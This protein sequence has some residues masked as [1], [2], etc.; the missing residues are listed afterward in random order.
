M[1][2]RRTRIVS[3]CLAAA[4]AAW[5][6][7]AGA[8]T[9]LAQRPPASTFEISKI[10]GA[11]DD[12]TPEE[13]KLLNQYFDFYLAIFYKPVRPDDQA[14]FRTKIYKVVAR[15][16]PKTKAH[17]FVN[18]KLLD[19]M[20]GVLRSN[21]DRATKYNAML[22]IGD[23]NESEELRS[24]RPMPDALRYLASL[25]NT[26]R[27]Q[28]E[29]LKPAALIGLARFAEEKAIP[30]EQAAELS[31]TLLKLVEQ[32][33]PPPGRNASTHNFMRR[34]AARALAAM[35][36]AG[37]N[38]RVLATF[39]AIAADPKLRPSFRCEFSRFIG[40]LEFPQGAKVD[41]PR[42]ASVL[43]HQAVEV[44]RQELDR[45]KAAGQGGE[46]PSRRLFLYALDC[47]SE[48]L[49]KLAAASAGDKAPGDPTV[50]EVKRKIDALL[51]EV[52]DTEKTPDSG[53]ADAVEK[54]L[55][56]IESVL[57]P[58]PEPSAVAAEAKP[59]AAK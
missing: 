57:P 56:E 46:V 18:K 30:K 32:E 4:L 28:F 53:L 54:G 10:I 6:L 31:Q 5:G 51:R 43:G 37:P 15:G 50:A 3:L 25:V 36:S 59:V 39:E 22:L 47:S 19:A 44:C 11:Q 1:A 13:E 49:Q 16:A 14:N 52:D 58:K 8:R 26:D 45:A 9:A 41:Y 2:G 33:N 23:L 24:I 20:T 35:K 7:V 42:L 27:P 21:A 17:D 48:G 38:N 29:Y 55:A 34:S 40:E 12:L